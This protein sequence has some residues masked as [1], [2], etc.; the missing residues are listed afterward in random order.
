[1]LDETRKN[2]AG[3]APYPNKRSPLNPHAPWPTLRPLVVDQALVN[4]AG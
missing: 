1:M 3:A 4:W 2:Q